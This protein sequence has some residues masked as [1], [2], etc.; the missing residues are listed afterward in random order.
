[1]PGYS[2]F[3]HK[4]Q[5]LLCHFF[6]AVAFDQR[7]S[8]CDPPPRAFS[9]VNSLQ[10]FTFS[11]ILDKFWVA[12]KLAAFSHL[13]HRI[14]LHLDPQEYRPAGSPDHDSQTVRFDDLRCIPAAFQSLVAGWTIVLQQCFRP[15]VFVGVFPNKSTPKTPPGLDSS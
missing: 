3:D 13:R 6:T 12:S 10:V 2:Y 9:F 5:V 7:F 4:L 15:P 1:M 11:E 8:P 14:F